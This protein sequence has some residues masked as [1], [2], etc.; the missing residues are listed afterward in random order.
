MTTYRNPFD[1]DVDRREIW[2]MVVERDTKAFVAGDWS[3]VEEDFLPDAF[4]AV[5]GRM[6][7]N[8]DS[9]RLGLSSLE[10]Y[11]ASWL[12]QSE[13][14]RDLVANLESGIYEVTTLRDI[15]VVQDRAL[16]HKKLD[17]QMRRKDGG[18]LS[19]HWQTLYMCRKNNGRWKITGFIGY[20]PHPMG[21]VAPGPAKELPEQA[22]QHDTAG[23][24]SPV[25]VLR[26]ASLAVISG[27][28]ALAQDGSVLGNGIEEQTRATLHNCARQL[29]TAGCTFRDVFKVNVYLADPDDWEA[30]N[31]V[32]SSAFPHPLPVRTTVGARL[33]NG[34]LVEIEMWAV[35]P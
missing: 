31:G 29:E 34:L 9:W 4:F 11:R 21:G 7:S 32:Y 25:L 5:D 27:Q 17:G 26:P 35:K 13:A 24:Y 1:L 10:E 23:P 28:A 18:T 19:L 15:E 8:P 14:M 22:T 33:L 20:L 30:F 12:E 3:L 16:A 2:E 6:R